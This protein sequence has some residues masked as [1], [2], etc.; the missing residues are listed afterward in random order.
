[1]LF[2]GFT[3]I[4]QIINFLILL[5]LLR[6]FLYKPIVNAMQEREQR[7]KS[8]L[9]EAEEKLSEAEREA[10]TYR[11]NNQ[12]LNEKREEILRQADTEAE[13]LRREM[14]HQAREEI[15]QVKTHWQQAVQQEKESFLR[16]LRLRT[17]EQ[18]CLVIRQALAD[19]AN[20]DLERQIAEVFLQ[21]LKELDGEARAE[22]DS[23]LHDSVSRITIRSAFE[24]P[25]DLQEQILSVV[26]DQGVKNEAADFE[27]S[28]D[29]LCGIELRVP[30]HKIG[31]S[32][33]SYLHSLEENLMAALD[34]KSV[35]A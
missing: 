18:A 1:M 6:R 22:M 28:S 12:E 30:G 31:W 15:H 13:A 19:L 23:V 26:N 9:H 33:A 27:V 20:A 24:I 21:R 32:L 2:D 14:L 3:F 7:I 8:R 5:F 10:Q 29:V 34:V 11:Q 17:G 35:E 16:E 25:D 4:A